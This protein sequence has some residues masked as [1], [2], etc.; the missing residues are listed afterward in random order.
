[1]ARIG[2]EADLVVDDEMDRA[3]RAVALEAREPEAFRDH[4]LPGERRVAM[5]QERHDGRALARLAV[6]LILLRAHLAEHDGID[7]LEMRRVGGERQMH[8]VAVELPVRRRAEMILDVARPLD[9]VRL[10]GAALELV[11]NGAERLGH[12]VGEHVETPAV[13]H[14]D[15][16]LAHAELAAALDD[17]LERR[18][19]RFAAVEPEALGARV[20][21]VGEPL[22]HLRFDEL[23]EDGRLALLREADVL[24]VALDAVLDPRLLSR[25]RD[26]HELVADLAAVGAP[27]DA[28]HLPDR[29]RVEAEVAVHEDRAIEIGVREAVRLGLELPVHA[30][31]GQA[32]G[33]EIRRQVPHDAIGADQHDGAHAVLDGAQRDRRRDLEPR[34]V[35]PCLQPVAQS[36]L[37][38]AIIAGQRCDQ[39]ARRSLK[40]RQRLRPGRPGR[41]SVSAL[42]VRGG[43]LGRAIAHALEEKAPFVADGARIFLVLALQL[44]DIGRVDAV[45]KRRAKKMLV[46]GLS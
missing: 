36:A 3:A 33:I 46:E 45:Q 38:L 23:P 20:L 13:R 31:V 9:V 5:D 11:E 42:A 2:G 8:V 15:H 10:P 6:E 17:L 41:S 21:H 39:R 16:D 14:A 7:D 25:R 26:V 24:L 28:Q 37:D 1:M 30:P 4:A 22:E 40:L 27:E 35:G 34:G 29:R 19:H 32:E 44:F 43:R 12:D 18:D